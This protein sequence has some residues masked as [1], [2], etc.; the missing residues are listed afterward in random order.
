[1]EIAATIERIKAAVGPRGWIADPSDQEPYLVEARGLYRGATRLV[2]RPASTAEVAAVVRICAEAKLPIVP[3]GGNTGLAANAVRLQLHALAYNLGNFM[4]TFAMPETAEPWSLTSLREK[5]DKDRRQGH[6]P[7]P[8][9]HLPAGRGRGVAADV[10]GDADAH[11]PAAARS[12]MKELW[13]ERCGPTMGEL[14]LDEGKATSSSA[15]RGKSRGFGRLQRQL[16]S[17]F[18]VIEAEKADHSLYTPYIGEMS[19]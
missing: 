18:V 11:R 13:V 7:W 12:S 19:D 16:W 8:L 4:R 10:R 6:Q 1:M 14:R 9:R 15:P 17:N 3:Q 2:V 5:L